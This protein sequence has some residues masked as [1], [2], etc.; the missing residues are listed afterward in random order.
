MNQFIGSGGGLA[1]AATLSQ[2]MTGTLDYAL[3]RRLS[4]S[5]LLGFARNDSLS[6][7]DIDTLT[8]QATTGLQVR[9][10]SWLNGNARYSY[11]KQE[12][13]SLLGADAHRNTV[14]VGLTAIALPW[15]VME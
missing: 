6:T 12:S 8:Y 14:F 1:A 7:D 10:L 4:G 11:I 5:L 3:A 9:L 15:R 13:K 2:S